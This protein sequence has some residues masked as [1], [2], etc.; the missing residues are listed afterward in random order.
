M[1]KRENK[2]KLSNAED[3]SH[4]I[5]TSERENLMV[6]ARRGIQTLSPGRLLLIA[7]MSTYYYVT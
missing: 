7:D 3:E 5:N 6:Q 4:V 1:E 2:I